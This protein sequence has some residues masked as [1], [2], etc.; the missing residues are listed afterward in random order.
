LRHCVVEGF[1]A[2]GERGGCVAW[3][4]PDGGQRWNVAVET[5]LAF[6]ARL[7]EQELSNRAIQAWEQSSGDWIDYF[8]F[9]RGVLSGEN[10]RWHLRTIDDATLLLGP[11]GL[12]AHPA[13]DKRAAARFIRTAR[14][15]AWL[16]AMEWTRP[17]RRAVGLGK[18]CK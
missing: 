10:S 1:F 4:I 12:Q 6:G 15:A 18:S 9:R 17:L 14:D 16:T 11:S 5:P 3:A 13:R 8:V 7:W 2:C